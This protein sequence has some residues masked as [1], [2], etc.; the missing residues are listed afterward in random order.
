MKYCCSSCDYNWVEPCLLEEVSSAYREVRKILEESMPGSTVSISWECLDAILAEVGKTW[1]VMHDETG[2]LKGLLRMAEGEVD[3]LKG[4][5]EEHEL[6]TNKLLH[7]IYNLEVDLK[8][9]KI[10]LDFNR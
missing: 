10:M 9:V 2:E 3:Y 6:E 4:E 8:R 5:C 7:R 1:G